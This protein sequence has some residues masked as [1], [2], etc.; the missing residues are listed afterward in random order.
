MVF[1]DS[2]LRTNEQLHCRAHY[3]K[4]SNTHTCACMLIQYGPIGPAVH[5]HKESITVHLAHYNSALIHLCA[6][7]NACTVYCA[8]T[9]F[10]RKIK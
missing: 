3:T 5:M 2:K 10:F 6:H 9:I 1:F 7:V 4:S 8:L